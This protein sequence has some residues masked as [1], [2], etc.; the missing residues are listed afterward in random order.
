MLKLWVA[1]V[2]AIYSRAE[3]GASTIS[4]L[5]SV[6]VPVI[7]RSPLPPTAEVKET[8]TRI[9]RYVPAS[10]LAHHQ[11]NG[12]IFGTQIVIIFSIP[13]LF[14]SQQW[15]G[16]RAEYRGSSQHRRVNI[17]DANLPLAY[18]SC[19]WAVPLPTAKAV[20]QTRCSLSREVKTRHRPPRA[21]VA[22]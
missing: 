5:I 16:Q 6:V 7:D 19:R 9:P 22:A 15:T 11:L 2:T 13:A 12:D 18:D 10:H 4:P 8:A 21:T 20:G 14:E 3:S 1:H 17:K